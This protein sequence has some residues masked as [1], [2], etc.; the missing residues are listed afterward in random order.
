MVPDTEKFKNNKF[1]RNKMTIDI[2]PVYEEI[3]N[4][5]IIKARYNEFRNCQFTSTTELNPEQIRQKLSNLE[6]LCSPIKHSEG[7]ASLICAIRLQKPV[8]ELLLLL[9]PPE[10]EDRRCLVRLFGFE[11]GDKQFPLNELREAIRIK[12]VAMTPGQKQS[13]H[14]DVET[15]VSYYADL[16]C[17]HRLRM[18]SER[19]IIE[20]QDIFGAQRYSLFLGEYCNQPKSLAIRKTEEK[21]GFRFPESL[22]LFKPENQSMGEHQQN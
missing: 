18:Y 11:T 14:D 15:Y 22:L 6:I 4:G 7:D 19:R 9:L 17:N 12:P 21:F 5:G 13:F 16:I 3:E 20:L 2:I 8:T 10:E 1:K